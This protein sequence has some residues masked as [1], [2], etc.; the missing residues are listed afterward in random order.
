MKSPFSEWWKI[1]H[2]WILHPQ[3]QQ[4]AVVIPTR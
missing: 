2:T 1:T 3:A 4:C